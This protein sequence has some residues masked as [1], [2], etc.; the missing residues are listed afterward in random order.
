MLYSKISNM[1]F[2]KGKKQFL[3][4]LMMYNWLHSI[5]GDDEN[6]WDEYLNKILK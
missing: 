5:S 4:I 2:I 6:Y 3:E 1:P